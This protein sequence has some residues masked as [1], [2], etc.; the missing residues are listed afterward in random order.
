MVLLMF[1]CQG[2]DSAVP[3]PLVCLTRGFADPSFDELQLLDA[4]SAALLRDVLSW[5][6]RLGGVI[7]SCSVSPHVSRL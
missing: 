6:W 4:S 1:S 7:L 5:Y 2:D 3:C